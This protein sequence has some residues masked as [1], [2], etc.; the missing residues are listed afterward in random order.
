MEPLIKSETARL[1]TEPCPYKG[2]IE[3][4]ITVN[5]GAIGKIGNKEMEGFSQQGRVP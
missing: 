2:Q 5:S 3:A 1:L 4:R